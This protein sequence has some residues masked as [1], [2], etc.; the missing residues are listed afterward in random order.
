MN[1]SLDH[2]AKEKQRPSVIQRQQ[3][4]QSSMGICQSRFKALQ[5]IFKL[6][7]PDSNSHH[8]QEALHRAKFKFPVRQKIIV[9]RKWGFT[10]FS[11]ADYL[12]WKSENRMSWSFG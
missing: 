8:A 12:R 7:H 4:N 9:S 5:T 10:K 6:F 1:D 2:R 11:R 3:S